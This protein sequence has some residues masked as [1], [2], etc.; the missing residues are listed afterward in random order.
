MCNTDCSNEGL[1]N[2]IPS[3]ITTCYKFTIGPKLYADED[4]CKISCFNTPGCNRYEY[5]EQDGY[6]GF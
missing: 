6:N 1:L 3:T 4:L 2:D 5:R